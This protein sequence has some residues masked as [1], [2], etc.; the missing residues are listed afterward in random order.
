MKRVVRKLLQIGAAVSL[1]MLLVFALI[2]TSPIRNLVGRYA[3][4]F[5]EKKFNLKVHI[6]HLSYNLLTLRISLRGLSVQDINKDGLP[7]LFKAA[8]IQAKLPVS[9]LLRRR[10]VISDLAGSNLHL[11]IYKNQHGRS[12]IPDFGG[13]NKSRNN[14]PAED[15]PVFRVGR[16]ILSDLSIVYED[17]G[18]DL[19]LESPLLK[20]SLEWERENRHIFYIESRRAGALKYR[21]RK[22]VLQSLS[23]K[24]VLSENLLDLMEFRLETSREKIKVS[25]RID[26]LMHPR[27]DLE[28]SA[29]VGGES[30]RFWLSGPAVP[31]GL[32]NVR[33]S[34]QGTLPSLQAELNIYS[35]NFTLGPVADI[36]FDVRARWQDQFL[37]VESLRIELAGGKIT[38][39]GD[40]HPRDGSGRNRV[41]LQWRDLNLSSLTSRLSGIP[42]LSSKASGRIAA[43]WEQWDWAGLNGSADLTFRKPESSQTG[44]TAPPPLWGHIR[45]DVKA[46]QTSLRVFEL[47]TEDA[48]LSG[49]ASMRG[50]SLSGKCRIEA[51]DLES[52]GERYLPARIMDRLP[53][54]AGKLM[55]SGRLAGTIDIPEVSSIWRGSGISVLG[56][57]GLDLSGEAVWEDQSVTIRDF[58]LASGTMLMNF[59][60]HYALDSR[61][62]GSSIDFAVSG[63]RLEQGASFFGMDEELKGNL[64]LEGRLLGVHPFPQLS[65]KGK[66][67]GIR[68]SELRLEELLLGF[69]V[70]EKKLDFSISVPAPSLSIRG[71]LGLNPPFIFNGSLEAT[72]V[73]LAGIRSFIKGIPHVDS[74][75]QLTA[76]LEFEGD[77]ESYHRAEISGSIKVEAPHLALLEPS[78]KF[79]NIELFLFLDK[80]VADIKRFSFRVND[81]QMEMNGGIPFYVFL[82]NT[83]DY[84][85]GQKNPGQLSLRFEDLDP[86]MLGSAFGKAFPAQLMGRINGH[87]KMTVPALNLNSLGADAHIDTLDLRLWG[88]PLKSEQPLTVRMDSGRIFT[89]NLNLKGEGNSIRIAGALDLARSE[90]ESLSL[91]GKGDLIIVQSFLDRTSVSGTSRY[92]IRAEGPFDNPSFRGIMDLQGVQVE[93]P[94]P[95]LYASGLSG[96]VRLAG[97]QIALTGFEGDLN[98]GNFRL[99]G[100]LLHKNLALSA[101]TLNVSVD[102][103]NMDYPVGF[104]SLISGEFSLTSDGT[105]HRLGG[106]F[107]LQSAEY[108]EPFHVESD[109]FRLLKS[110][111]RGDIY[112]KRNRFLDD[113][114]FDIQIETLNPARIENN[115]AEARFRADL[116][117]TGSPYQAG[118]SGRI[119][120]VEG[121]EVHISGNT[122]RIEQGIIDF[123]DPSRI[124]P[125]IG[126]R[127]RTRV[128][129]YLIQLLVYG[130]PDD[131]SARLESD[132]PLAESDIMSLLLTGRRLEYVSSTLL[133]AVG[134]QALDYVEGAV[135]GR[136]ERIAEKTFGLDNVRIDTSLIAAQENPEA[137][138]TVG[139]SVTPDL[140]LVVSQGLRETDELMLMLSYRPLKNVDLRAVKQ[141]NDAYQF[142]AMHELRFGLKSRDQMGPSYNIEQKES[143][144]TKTEFNGDLGIPRIR[145]MSKLALKPGERFDFFLYQEDLER[146]RD[147]YL[148]NDYLEFELDSRKQESG[149][150]VALSYRIASGP[151]VLLRMSGAEISRAARKQAERLWMEGAF[152]RKRIEDIRWFLKKIFFRKGYYQLK[153]KIEENCISPALKIVGIQI[154][155]GSKYER[156]VYELEGRRGLAKQTLVSILEEPEAML[157]LLDDPAA[158]IKEVEEAYRRHGYL[159]VAVQVPRIDFEREDRTVV[160]YIFIREGALFLIDRIELRG[161]LSLDRKALL[162]AAGVSE[163]ESFSPDILYRAQSRLEDLYSEHGFINARVD[164]RIEPDPEQG[165][166]GLIFDIEENRKEVIEDIEIFGNKITKAEIIERELSF[167]PGQAVGYRKFSAAQ[168]KLYS[169]GTFNSIRIDSHP[170]DNKQIQRDA[171]SFQKPYRVDVLV[172]EVKPYYLRYGAQYD[173]ETGL[174]GV[175]ELVR[176]N[177]LGKAIETGGNIQVNLRE[178]DARLF[179]RSPYF[180]GKR[181]DTSLFTFATRKEE[182]DITTTRSGATLQQQLTIEKEFVIS[183]HYTFECLHNQSGGTPL[184]DERYNIG[185]ISFSLSRDRRENLF[186]SLQGSFISLT[187][188]YAEKILASDVRYLRFFGQY[189]LYMPLGRSLTYAAALRTGL[190]W[191]LGRE[192]VPSERFFAGGGSSLRGFGYHEAGPKNPVTGNPIGGNAVFILNQEL[193]FP[194]YR[195]LSGVVFL[196]VGNVYSS[197]ADFDLLGTRK[198][199]GL[200]ARVDLGFALG[201]LDIG[202]KLDRMDGESPCR[203]HFSLGQAF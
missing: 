8:S 149:E 143:V 35:R 108:E 197:I 61:S 107:S 203:L 133:D 25:G 55:V 54:L 45:A 174:G 116:K 202:F 2:H 140:D 78:L 10:L 142:D 48:V 144:I 70:R 14:S 177:L 121:G 104:R 109:L 172:E 156:V 182:A 152:A 73:S 60:G 97:K 93:F 67:T 27:L 164:S 9:S 98:G 88:I 33:A 30:L 141:D 50:R 125:D 26:N 179:F 56:M 115:L 20:L 66:L 112:A 31:V 163:E 75:G 132:P 176:R 41:R 137:R 117:L 122:Y 81:A 100:T 111:G 49:E 89:D 69:D 64:E 90:F 167:W 194:L 38:G 195:R 173:T 102:G 79:K 46:Q 136:V 127:A 151:K 96:E 191:G 157:S 44:G 169:L 84:G 160:V 178:R 188:E 99:V 87:V 155:L 184:P 192:L 51:A 146:I 34:F 130:T 12:N 154:S 126:F 28:L 39:G 128:S 71:H 168:K 80:R 6:S 92:E 170:I 183:Y 47:R 180:L 91:E 53:G 153:I 63:F 24:G 1:V 186:D 110:K 161:R 113:L 162:A 77:V 190:G 40:L 42:F 16:M 119:D 85:E 36:G 187:G 15:F 103:I 131:L 200:G 166:I 120:F 11:F 3:L 17:R 58:R 76:R 118:L 106:E 124:V 94:D 185:R 86:F 105:R 138:I 150:K 82:G 139:Q 101:A 123:I 83:S 181:M 198:T 134:A 159:N 65:G 74:S 23:A 147:L 4:N 129:G 52:I 201:R 62:V 18:Q 189:F 196:D 135:L 43:E 5:L 37:K 59:S 68:F 175:A 193:R 13:S 21:D 114:S 19:N 57:S 158:A 165:R 148:K 7:V 72:G 29:D 22:N 171:L 199:A 32:V 95:D 145:L